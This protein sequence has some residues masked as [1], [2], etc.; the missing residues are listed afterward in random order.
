MMRNALLGWL[1]NGVTRD[2]LYKRMDVMPDAVCNAPV[3]VNEHIT[4]AIIP[5]V[6]VVASRR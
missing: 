3:V 4:N 1:L 6:S 2:E 5:L